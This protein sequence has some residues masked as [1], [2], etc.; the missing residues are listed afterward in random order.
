MLTHSPIRGNCLVEAYKGVPQT[1][2]D[3]LRPADDIVGSTG[4]FHI[5]TGGL[6]ADAKN[7]CDFPVGLAGGDET[8]ALALASAQPGDPADRGK[9]INPAGGPER[10]DADQLGAQQPANRERP[11]A[12]DREGTGSGRLSRH[13]G[14]NGEARTEAMK[15][16]ALEDAPLRGAQRQE[17]TNLVPPEAGIRPEAREV[18]GI[19]RNVVPVEQLFLPGARIIVEANAIVRAGPHAPVMQKREIMESKLLRGFFQ[20][21]SQI[22]GAG[23]SGRPLL[24]LIG[25]S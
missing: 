14:R 17:P 20:K 7:G 13:I 21:K 22:I 1:A 8:Q 23:A 2:G 10:M 9:S 3:E 12:S 25:E 24:E 15:P 11:A 4:P 16:A 6:D 19:R 18:D 5:L